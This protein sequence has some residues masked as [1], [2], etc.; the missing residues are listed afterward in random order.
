MKGFIS[1]FFTKEAD[2]SVCYSRAFALELN[3]ELSNGAYA[4]VGNVRIVARY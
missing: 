3:E 2:N 1:I 4:Y